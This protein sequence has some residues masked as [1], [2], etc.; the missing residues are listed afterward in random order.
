MPCTYISFQEQAEVAIFVDR[1]KSNMP[2]EDQLMLSPEDIEH[3]NIMG[4]RAALV[5]AE[6]ERRVKHSSGKKQV[7]V[8]REQHGKVQPKTST[9]TLLKEKAL[10]TLNGSKVRTILAPTPFFTDAF[11][12]TPSISTSPATSEWDSATSNSTPALSADSGISSFDSIDSIYSLYSQSDVE[13]S[14]SV[15]LP[16]PLS[17]TPQFCYDFYGNITF[18]GRTAIIDNNYAHFIKHRLNNS[19]GQGDTGSHRKIIQQYIDR[20]SWSSHQYTKAQEDNNKESIRPYGPHQEP[21]WHLGGRYISER[22]KLFIGP[23]GT[24]IYLTRQGQ[25]GLEK[26]AHSATTRSLSRDKYKNTVNH[27]YECKFKAEYQPLRS[28][29]E[30]RGRW[31]ARAAFEHNNIMGMRAALLEAENERR[32]KHSSSKQQVPVYRERMPR[33]RKMYLHPY[34]QF[35]V[36]ASFR[37]VPEYVQPKISAATLLKEKALKAPNGTAQDTN[38]LRPDA[39]VQLSR[40]RSLG[41]TTHRS[42][43][44][45]ITPQEYSTI[46]RS[47]FK[48]QGPGR[49]SR[50]KGTMQTHDT[51][52]ALIGYDLT[53][54][55]HEDAGAQVNNNKKTARS[56]EPHNR[57]EPKRHLNGRYVSQVYTCKYSTGKGGQDES[58]RKTFQEMTG[59]S[60][61]SELRSETIRVTRVL[62][63]GH[64]DG[65]AW[66]SM[67]FHSS[68]QSHLGRIDDWGQ[69]ES[70]PTR[71]SDV[72]LWRVR[73][74]GKIRAGPVAI[75]HLAYLPTAPLPDICWKAHLSDPRHFATRLVFF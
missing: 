11:I 22:V 63:K 28:L 57:E 56:H 5:E 44:H 18:P 30:L 40:R 26:T 37:L 52:I 29:E 20:N 2:F 15:C 39:Q 24:Q 13:S 46:H 42:R 31:E 55:G 6:N 38:Y 43:G 33:S 58:C 72:V 19:S 21:E 34:S 23:H 73:G 49:Q 27:Q 75:F 41:S 14:E 9:A 60:A 17:Q 64:F 74:A 65:I 67:S 66:N 7:P 59:H 61:K 36:P 35:Q 8:Y 51:S 12:S 70:R 1:T 68:E 53:G 62:N 47:D 3:N 4:M 50:G 10:K 48:L 45:W 54:P 25:G 71:N 69:A 16:T 32:V